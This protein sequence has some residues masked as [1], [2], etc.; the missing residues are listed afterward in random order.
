MGIRAG[1]GFVLVFVLLLGLLAPLGCAQRRSGKLVSTPLAGGPGRTRVAGAAHGVAPEG[2]GHGNLRVNQDVSGQLQNE[3]SLAVDPARPELVLGAAIDRRLGFYSIG[4]YLSRDAGES[5]VDSV[6][7]HRRYVS[8]FDPSV[9]YC[10][11]GTALL[12]YLDTM[13]EGFPHRLVVTRSLDGGETWL[14]PG[15][16]YEGTAPLADRPY[17]A[18]APEGGAHPNRAYVVW[19]S[20]VEGVGNTTR[21]AYSDDRGQTWAGVQTISGVGSNI[22]PMVAAGRDGEVWASWQGDVHIEVARSLDGGQSWGP[23]L[24]PSSVDAIGP[25]PYFRRWSFPTIAVDRSEGEFAGHVY[26]VWADQRG[27]D[28]DILFTRSTDGGAS[29]SD[30]FRVNDDTP[31]LGCDQ[32]FPW[33][34]VDAAGGVHVMWHDHRSDPQNRSYHVYLASSRDGGARF[35]RNQRLTDTASDGSL[36]SF[37]GDYAALGVG[38]ER[39]HVLWADLRA[40]N[41]DADLYLET[42]RAYGYDTVGSVR[43]LSDG[44]SLDFEE[45]SPRQGDAIVYDLLI[46]DVGELGGAAPWTNATCLAEDLAGPPAHVPDEP[47]P[48]HAL[49]VLLRASGPRGT[50]SYGWSSGHPDTRDGFDESGPCTP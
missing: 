17:V 1:V 13:G 43:F 23:V 16:P 3:P 18:C 49:Y 10:G 25:G 47:E 33:M 39:V 42:V 8:Q 29:W 4:I 34:A 7:P 31:G 28:A 45:L 14:A 44:V 11:D 38:G 32:Y 36:A 48:G 50:G 5:F 21:A 15:V 30:P 19:T 6:T 46:G 37:L 20:V 24:R 40:G 22:G 9:A 27:G 12:G 41:G 35:D 2:L 26:L